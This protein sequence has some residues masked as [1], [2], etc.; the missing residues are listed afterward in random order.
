MIAVSCAIRWIVRCLMAPKT[1]DIGQVKCSDAGAR[2]IRWCE[3]Q[4]DEFTSADIAL[5]LGWSRAHATRVAR[6]ISDAGFIVTITA[7]VR[8][9]PMRY[10]SKR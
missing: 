9:V 10:R 8:G 2:L 7:G 1:V 6:E 5:A 4:Q 3:R